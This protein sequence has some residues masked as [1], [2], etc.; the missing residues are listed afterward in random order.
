MSNWYDDFDE[1]LR[2]A[3]VLIE[4]DFLETPRDAV[5]YMEKPWKYDG[6]YET[7]VGCGEP[8]HDEQGWNFFV[9]KLEQR[10][11]ES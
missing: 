3:D 5:Y 10:E 1:R 6:E 2:F 4:L 11:S 7:W 8:W 9:K